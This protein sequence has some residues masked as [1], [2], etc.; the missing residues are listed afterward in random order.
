VPGGCGLC[1]HAPAQTIDPTNSIPTPASKHT[2]GA[3]DAR[4]SFGSFVGM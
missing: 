4:P 3:F 2:Q 1:P